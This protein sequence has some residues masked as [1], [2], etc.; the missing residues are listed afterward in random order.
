[1]YLSLGVT[2]AGTGHLLALPADS[3]AD[4][5]GP[6]PICWEIPGFGG[7][8]FLAHLEHPSRRPVVAPT[9]LMQD[10]EGEISSLE[11]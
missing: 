9:L 1:M 11:P 3:I 2:E 8:G 10:S 7:F 5:E 6:R 4:L